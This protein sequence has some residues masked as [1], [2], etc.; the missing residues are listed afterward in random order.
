MPPS[1]DPDRRPEEH[2]GRIAAARH[3]C[4]TLREAIDDCGFTRS[5]LGRRVDWGVYVRHLPGVYGV[6]GGEEGRRTQLMAALLAAGR[7][8]VADLGS[9]AAL[10]QLPDVPLPDRPRILVPGVTAPRVAGVGAAGAAWLLPEDVTTIGVVPCLRPEA[11]LVRL[12]RELDDRAHLGVAAHLLRV[13]QLRLHRL[14]ALIG[15]CGSVRGVRR[16]RRTLG[17]L[18]PA[19]GR[20]A[21][22]KEVAVLATV[23]GSDLPRPLVNAPRRLST[24]RLAIF[25][26]LWEPERVVREVDSVLAH[27]IRP[28]MRRDRNRDRE[29]RDDGYD[30]ERWMWEDI[31]EQPEAFVEDCRRAIA[32]R[33]EG[34][35]GR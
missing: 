21:S 11:L 8:A 7:G 4:V 9:A 6:R 25:D 33:R 13:G 3:N 30:V 1:P 22:V 18:D 15:R 29:A 19:Y 12:A 35:A 16:A 5:A 14:G 26:L 2:F 17:A 20:A 28:D 10:W 24:G 31:Q 32:S 23:L 34:R 27:G